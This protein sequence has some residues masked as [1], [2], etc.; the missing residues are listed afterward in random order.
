MDE[1]RQQTQPLP[2]VGKMGGVTIRLQ[3]SVS[4]CS[5][6][7]GFSIGYGFCA[8]HE[9]HLN[10]MGQLYGLTDHFI[11][12]ATEWCSREVS[13]LASSLGGRG[14]YLGQGMGYP[15]RRFS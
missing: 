13:A 11:R 15:D 14:S 5:I 10:Q 4:S 1:E 3:Y 9:S 8:C 7:T 6:I 12:F 2:L